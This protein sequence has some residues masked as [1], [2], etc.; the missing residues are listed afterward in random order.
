MNLSFPP[1][2]SGSPCL[3]DNLHDTEIDPIL[4]AFQ[5][6]AADAR[7]DKVNLSVG[8]YYN[9]SGTIP[10]LKAVSAAAQRLLARNAPWGYLMPQG[11]RALC[12]AA[13]ALLFPIELRTALGARLVATQ[14]LGGTGAVRMAAD[15]YKSLNP[16]GQVAISRPTWL[17]HRAIFHAAGLPVIEYDYYSPAMGKVDIEAMCRSLAQFRPGTLVVVQGCCHNPTG[18][19]PTL[20]EWERVATLL[21]EHDLIALVDLAYGGF[22]DGLETDT[23]P[24]RILVQKGVRVMTALSFSK[25]FALYGER[26]GV[27]SVIVDTDRQ[28]PQ[29]YHTMTGLSRTTYSTPP[30][31]GAMIIAEVLN[32][33]VLHAQ[34]KAELEEMRQRILGV[35]KELF[36][37]LAGLAHDFSVIVRQKGLFSYTGFSPR[38]MMTMKRDFSVHGVEDG[39]ICVAAINA[40]NIDRVVHAMRQAAAD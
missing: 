31:H 21:A 25:S 11:Y 4:R 35:R 17:N 40:H 33:T 22:G 26:V 23:A 14:T 5:D 1:L 2:H 39:R 13:Q 20:A 27:L 9:E 24:V 37:R 15:L 28:V 38:T 36:N 16:T 18:A 7:P 3:F 10:V 19:D 29:L 8:M 30:S 34:W 12:D 6:F 32:D